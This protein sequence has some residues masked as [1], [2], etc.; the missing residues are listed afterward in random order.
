MRRNYFLKARDISQHPTGPPKCDLWNRKQ[1]D[2]RA[3]EKGGAN[4]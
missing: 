1:S 2:R 4:R 3:L